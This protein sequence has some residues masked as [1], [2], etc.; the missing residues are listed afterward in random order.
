MATHSR[1]RAWKI[2]RTGEPGRLQS[3]G[4]HVIP[5]SQA[6]PKAY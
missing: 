6:A 4:S 1:I 3:R 5:K 2:L